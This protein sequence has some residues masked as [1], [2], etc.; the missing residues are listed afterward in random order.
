MEYNIIERQYID[1]YGKANSP[2]YVI[3]FKK[4]FLWWSYWKLLTHRVCVMFDVV[5]K[6]PD[7]PSAESFAKTYLCEGQIFNGVK[8]TVVSVNKCI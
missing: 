2:F 6:F 1:E 3:S 5:T 7:Q 4:R 8:E